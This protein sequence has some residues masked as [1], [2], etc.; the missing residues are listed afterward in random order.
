MKTKNKNK[1]QTRGRFPNSLSSFPFSAH[2]SL[3]LIMYSPKGDTIA[4]GSVDGYLYFLDSQDFSEKGK[5]KERVER[6]SD[7]KFS[8]N[9]LLVAVG[10]HDNFI[11]IYNTDT[12]RREAVC[13][14]HSSF[15]THLG[16]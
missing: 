10:T 3:I 4:V 14:G 12:Y 2:F 9:G 1:K 5:K 13:K 15:I 6:V 11:D 7:I 8:P 16:N